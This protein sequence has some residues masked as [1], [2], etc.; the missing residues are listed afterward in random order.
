MNDFNGSVAQQDVTITT[1]VKK[2]AV[3]GGNYYEDIL[4]VTDRFESFGGDTPVYPVVTKATYED[5]LADYAYFNA[6]EKKIIKNN[7]DSLFQYGV[8]QKV[9]IIPSTE[10]AN[11]KLYAYFT[12]LDLQW[13]STAGGDED[14][15]LDGTSIGTVNNVKDFDKDF[16]A[17]ITEFPVDPTKMKGT[18]TTTTQKTLEQLTAITDSTGTPIDIAVFARPAIPTGSLGTVNC[19]LDGNGDNVS[20][21]P[22]LYQLG[23]TLDLPNESGTPVA[24]TFDMKALN[25]I[26][27]MPTADT[28]VEILS[29]ASATF[30]NWFEQKYVNYFKPVGNGT[31]DL[32]NMGGWTTRANC[33]VANWIVAY[34]NYMNRV[35][36]AIVISSGKSVKNGKTYS[37]LLDVVKFNM[38][39][40]VATGRI[41]NFNLT[42]PSF[43]ELPTSNGHTIIIPNAWNAD[44]VDNVRK[45]RISGTLTVA[46]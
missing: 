11:Y 22:C 8:S 42:A 12:Y 43:G 17:L 5:A 15:T 24:N 10:V 33:V 18:S 23:W 9:Y 30:A 20:A 3:V 16:T 1:E 46:M 37:E 36:C 7:L 6:T 26:N 34:E 2:T 29:G 13:L 32:V 44:F 40:M 39:K 28:S 38:S 25:F 19:Y 45:V 41:T 27:V 31:M 21:S 14:Y 4:Y 35:G